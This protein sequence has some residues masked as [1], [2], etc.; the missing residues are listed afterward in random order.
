[1]RTSASLWGI[2]KVSPC[3]VML[4]GSGVRAPPL[5]FKLGV[6]SVYRIVSGLAV[7]CA[8]PRCVYLERGW[9]L[10]V[11]LIRTRWSKYIYI[12]IYD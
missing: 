11:A 5:V 2:I 4:L 6:A 12:Y 1:M 8:N 7:L 9:I 10:R 3:R